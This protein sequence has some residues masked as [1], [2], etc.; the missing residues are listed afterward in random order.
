MRGSFK[1]IN[2]EKE[3]GGELSFSYFMLILFSF[4]F[5]RI[6]VGLFGKWML[7]LEN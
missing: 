4:H 7:I 1:Q 5:R 6:S 2:K 3:M